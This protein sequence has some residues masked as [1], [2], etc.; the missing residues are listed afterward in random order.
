M[1]Y[2][3]DMLYTLNLHDVLCQLYLI[4]TGGRRT[5]KCEDLIVLE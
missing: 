2:H 1:K 4:K 5:P 3:I